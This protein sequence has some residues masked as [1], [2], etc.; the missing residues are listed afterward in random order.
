[1]QAGTPKVSVVMASYN[2]EA[3]VREAIGSVLNQSYQDFELVI[4]DDGSAD[5]TVKAIQSVSDP[6]IRLNVFKENQGACAAVNDALAR[7]RGDYIAVLNSDDYFL[8]GK[9]EKQVAF[10]DAN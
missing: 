8:P 1:M 3:F 6:R 7:A 4:T 10:V 5:G 9:L 2:H